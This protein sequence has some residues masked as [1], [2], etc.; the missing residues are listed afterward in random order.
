MKKLLLLAVA[1]GCSSG[2][3]TPSDSGASDSP[4]SGDV[5]AVDSGDS[6]TEGGGGACLGSVPLTY[7][8]PTDRS[9][10]QVAPPTLGPAGSIVKDPVYGTSILRVTDANTL[11]STTA[12]RVANEFWGNDWS[13]DGKL[14]YLQAST[15][16][17]MPYTLDP[18]TLTAARVKNNGDGGILGMPLAPGGFSRTEATVFYGLSGLVIEKYDF[19]TQT[20]STIVDLTAIV[21]GSSGYALGVEQGTNGLLA[22]SFGGPQQDKMPYIVTYDASTQTSH[23]LDV[24]TSMLDGKAL[25]TPMTGAQGVHT[26]K[27]DSSGQYLSFDVA[28]S[29]PISWVWDTKTNTIAPGNAGGALG[30]AAWGHGANADSYD[31]QVS[32]FAQ[33]DAST[34]LIT[35]LLTPTDKLASASIAWQNSSAGAGTPFI[36]ETIRQPTDTG[37]WRPWD[38]EIIGVRTDG[39][40]SEVWRFAHNWNTYTGTI[41]SDNFYY[42]FIPRVSQNG[43]FVL[44][45]S[46]WNGTLGTDA[47]GNPRTDAFIVALPNP[48]GP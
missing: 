33:P 40:Q 28:G 47:S 3:T 21:P 11:G 8:A 43:W 13:T 16:G 35:P 22:A 41:Y 27:L 25:P 29:T 30:W 17:F 15:S 4:S 23:V 45:D 42:L 24:L 7:N 19:A 26:F 31:W 48:C 46:N 44:F 12:F 6:G 34:A 36:V 38:G 5:V 32:T 9:P 20:K 18:K 2:G 39:A 14:F 10:H 1:V 37:P